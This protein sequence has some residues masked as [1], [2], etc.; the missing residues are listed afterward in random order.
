MKPVADAVVDAVVDPVADPVTAGMGRVGLDR[1]RC[2]V[3][4]DGTNAELTYRVFA[5]MAGPRLEVRFEPVIVVAGSSALVPPPGRAWVAGFG[6]LDDEAAARG[7]VRGLCPSR[8]RAGAA[9]P[10]RPNETPIVRE[11]SL[12]FTE[13]V[14]CRIGGTVHEIVLEGAFNFALREWGIKELTF[15]AIRLVV[16]R[17]SPLVTQLAELGL[18]RLAGTSFSLEG[19]LGFTPELAIESSGGRFVMTVERAELVIRKRPRRDPAYQLQSQTTE[20]ATGL[21]VTEHVIA[22][23]IDPAALEVLEQILA[24]SP[25]P[26]VAAHA[27]FFVG[28][29]GIQALSSHVRECARDPSEDLGVRMNAIWALVQL[30]H[31]GDGPLLREI[32]DT[33]SEVELRDQAMKALAVLDPSAGRPQR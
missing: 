32:S 16:D 2:E 23:P 12:A 7:H 8:L 5:C 27:A 3:D 19:E 17:A 1:F 13:R 14:P 20:L 11:T 9:K 15:V 22:P 4:V 26:I 33:A 30:G 31:A 24:G 25:D 28:K 18:R 29:H 6:E 21:A 10:A